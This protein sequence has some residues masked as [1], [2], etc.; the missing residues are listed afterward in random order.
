MSTVLE[1]NATK[2]AAVQKRRKA[3]LESFDD[4]AK[5]KRQESEIKLGEIEEAT[6][7][8]LGID[9]AAVFLPDGRLMVAHK[10][11]A[12]AHNKLMM[13]QSNGAMTDDI[14]CDYV[15]ACLE[16]PAT[17]IEAE[18][19]FLDFA[20]AREALVNAGI[21]LHAVNQSNLLGK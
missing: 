7:K 1:D 16:Y 10:P 20:N 19:M 2:L 12:A 13:A 3:R 5:L 8:T 21:Q 11:S 14:I 15:T 18:K 6:N 9:L 17:M 4:A